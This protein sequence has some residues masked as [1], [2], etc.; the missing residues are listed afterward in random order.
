[1]KF[2]PEEGRVW[3]D[4]AARGE[5]F[6]L[7]VGDT[8]MGI[9]PEEQE[10][11]FDEFHQV[12]AASPGTGLGLAITRKLARLHGGDVR[13]ESELGKGSRFLISLPAA[14]NLTSPLAL[15]TT[16]GAPGR[17]QSGN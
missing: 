13:V 16:A 6:T 4:A 2:T 1:M 8:G 3:I 7:C 5:T 17:G 12:A 9:P 10:A 11:I 15:E 14:G